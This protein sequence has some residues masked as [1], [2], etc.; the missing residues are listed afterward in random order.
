MASSSN[1]ASGPTMK[2][3]WSRSISSCALVL[4]PAGLPPVSPTTSSALR[5]A[6]L[7]PRCF[8]NRLIP[9][10]IWMPPWA[11]GPVFTVKSPILT[12]VSSAIAGSGRLAAKT[13]PAEPLSK[14]RRPT[15]TAIYLLPVRLPFCP[16]KSGGGRFAVDREPGVN[17]RD[18]L[19]DDRVA[20]AVLRRD[21]LHQAVGALDVGGTVEQRPRRRRRANQVVC[22]SSVFFE[23]HQIVRRRP[24]LLAH[25]HDPIVDRARGGEI[26]VNGVLD[27]DGALRGHASVVAGQQHRPF[28]QRHK[29]RVMDFEL[30]WQVD[31][32]TARIVAHGLDVGL[33]L[34]QYRGRG[35]GSKARDLE[36]GRQGHLQYVDLFP[37]RADGLRVGAAQG[38]EARV[39]IVPHAGVGEGRL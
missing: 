11:S 28:G 4:V 27:V 37:R 6:S 19:V 39:E 2:S 17:R 21:R 35:F 7:L 13:A 36:V 26:A 8:R 24:E 29:D 5:P 23:R 20:H 33:H 10:S 18:G 16:R 14:V 25:A 31:R 12:G 30:D 32:T 9:C 1:A 15:L 3:T 34:P 22:R 38:Y